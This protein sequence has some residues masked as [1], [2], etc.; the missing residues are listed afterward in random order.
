MADFVKGL[1]G[2]Q[3]PMPAPAAGDDDFA[4]YAGAPDPKP[5]AISPVT[6]LTGAAQAVPTSLGANRPY[7]AWYR[8]W[9]R[10]SIDDFQLEIYVLPFLFLLVAFHLWGT[11]RN[12][13][14]AKTWIKAHAPVLTQ[15]FAQVGY[16]RPQSEQSVTDVDSLL[17]EKAADEFQTYATGRQNVAFVDFRLSFSKGYNPFM[18]L[19]D[20]MLPL[21][22]ES[23]PPP[24]ERVGAT[25][26]VF[27][28]RETKIAPSY[29][30]GDAKKV[31]NSTFD[32]FVFAVVHKD[33]MKR[34]R[35]DRYDLSLTT[36][37]DHAKLPVW[38]TVMSE[39]AEVTDMLLTPELIKAIEQAG[40]NF[41]AIIVTDQPIDAPKTLD[42]TK[43]RKRIHLSLKYTSDYTNTMP[44]FQYFLRLPDFLATSAHFRPE[45]L[46][47]IK[48]TRDEQIA[49][50]RK[51]EDEE[52]AE[53]R[54][55]ALDKLKKEQRDAKLGRLSAEEQRKFLEKEREKNA[56]K[57][58]KRST[59]KA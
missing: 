29:G 5:A 53:E 42:E 26:Y 36:T 32:G 43:P 58:M 27:D 39:S 30:Q 50:I 56:R 52:K 10:T 51:A 12:R 11:S 21:F 55:L 18:W 45:A 33:M 15:E 28:G 16:T 35:E 38:T 48:Q 34:M 22:F 54:K 7:T 1:F 59:V 40:D 13:S 20:H 17:K 6:T 9:E 24:V 2:G 47:R 44:L 23:F 37:R 14:K 49:K 31:S 4:D 46:R 8:V 3:K 25:A 19:G 41:E 57:G